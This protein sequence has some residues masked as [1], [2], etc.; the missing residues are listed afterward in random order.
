M[1]RVTALDI[2]ANLKT[3]RD[4]SIFI[5]QA[6]VL[7]EET[8]VGVGLSENRLR[9]IELNLASHFT[10]IAEERGQIIRSEVEHTREQYGGDFTTGLKLTRF[11]QQAIMM[12]TSGTLAKFDSMKSQARFTVV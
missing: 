11:G 12:D 8:L 3:E 6:H 5:E 1:P 4:V 9:L 7:V 2:K 10:A